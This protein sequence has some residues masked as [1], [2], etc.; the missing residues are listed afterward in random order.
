[1]PAFSFKERFVPMVIDGSKSNTIRSFRNHPIKVGQLAHLYYGMRTKYC[2]KLIADSPPITNVKCIVIYEDGTLK[3]LSTN[4]LTPVEREQL[5]SGKFSM[6][7]VSI[8]TLSSAECDSLAWWDGF[9]HA[10]HPD[11]IYGCFDLMLRFW[12]QT[13][14][15]PFVGNFVS[16]KK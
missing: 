12:K 6:R 3:L 11:M 7:G 4:W 5:I 15:L 8:E 10:E 14:S 16:W 1:M 2:K 13:H 9:R